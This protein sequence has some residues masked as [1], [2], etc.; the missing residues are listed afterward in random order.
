M[1]FMDEEEGPMYKSLLRK[2]RK[3]LE[4]DRLRPAGE[5]GASRD[6]VPGSEEMD[7]ILRMQGMT[8]RYYDGL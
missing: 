6:V 1:S 2:L 4:L 3:D 8:K 5:R 7:E